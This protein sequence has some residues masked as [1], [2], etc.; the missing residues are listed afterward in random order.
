MRHCRVDEISID[1]ETGDL[2]RK[3]YEDLV[4]ESF[5][6]LFQALVRFND[7]CRDNSRE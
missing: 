3:V 2:S 5:R 4:R 1:S 6:L 7:E